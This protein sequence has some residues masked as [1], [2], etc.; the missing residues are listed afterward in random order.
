MRPA[1]LAKATMA[2]HVAGKLR[3]YGTVAVI[4]LQK[5]RGKQINEA[6]KTLRGLS[7][8]KQVKCTTAKLAVEK[9]GDSKPGIDKISGYLHGMILL[10]FSDLDPFK[11]QSMLRRNTTKLH[12]KA[13]DVAPE[14]IMVPAGNTGIA[15][16]PVI[17]ELNAV[18]IP[19]RID[20]G[21][22]WITKDTMVA[23]MGDRISPHLA[24]VLSKLNI[25]PISSY[26]VIRAAFQDGLIFESDALQIDTD[27]TRDGL[28]EAFRAAVNLSSQIWY[29]TG[30]NIAALIARAASL[31]NALSVKA[32]YPT[33]NNIRELLSSAQT[34]ASSLV[35]S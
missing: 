18:G 15:P 33:Q 7:E 16:G 26:L 2:D 20:T 3:E 35:K 22:V 19:T 6:R 29:A 30:Q 11:I 27:K 28:L 9:V 31:A 17:S 1:L 23:K 34:Q 10:L 13:G 4:D 25:T 14:D 12:A 5:V 21:S 8:I 32:W 24:A